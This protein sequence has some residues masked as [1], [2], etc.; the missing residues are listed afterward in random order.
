MTKNKNHINQL[1]LRHLSFL[2]LSPMI[3]RLLKNEGVEYVGDLVQIKYGELL[4]IPNLGHKSH[5]EVVLTLENYGLALGTSIPDWDEH[6]RSLEDNYEKSSMVTI[7]LGL[8]CDAHKCMI[9]AG[10][11]LAPENEEVK[12]ECREVDIK[13]WIEQQFEAIIRDGKRVAEQ[14]RSLE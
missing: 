3:N 8:I 13:K 5:M 14:R 12:E 9:D 6:K 4:R 7:P 10:W 2:N 1:Y 11:N